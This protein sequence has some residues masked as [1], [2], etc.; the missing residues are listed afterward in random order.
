MIKKPKIAWLH[1][2]ICYW[3]GGTK[4]IY[5]TTSELRKFYDITLFVEDYDNSVKTDFE[6][7][8]IKVKRSNPLSSNKAIYWIIF[9]LVLINEYIYFKRVLKNYDYVISSMF[10]MNILANLTSRG[11]HVQFIFEP[12]AFFYDKDMINGYPLIKKLALKLISRLYS[13]LDMLFT[14]K[15]RQILTVNKNV[16]EWIHK[17]YKKDSLPSYLIIDSAIFRPIKQNYFGNKLQDNKIVLHTTDYT[18]IKR[19]D[20]LIISF[21][22]VVKEVPSAILC[23]TH[24]VDDVDKRR[25]LRSLCKV[26]G[27]ERN[28][29]FLGFVKNEDLPNLYSSVNCGIYPG[30][31]SGASACSYFVLELM[32][33][34]TPVVRTSDSTEEIDDGV[35]GYLFDP[36]NESEMVRKL[37]ILLKNNKLSEKMGVQGRLKIKNI[38]CADNVIKN[39][40]LALKGVKYQN[41]YDRK[42]NC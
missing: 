2:H 41:N 39:F 23:I 8:N 9:P 5:R 40:N 42:S 27:I 11:K 29:K 1:T 12:F 33:C 31:G 21:V 26:L 30:I 20:Y 28:V 38:Y 24:T 37:V 17:I 35:S 32:S 15:S 19:T 13:W 4:F 10:P 7:N 6:K 25:E 16:S 22:E 34:A 36:Q 18:P 14:Q 3:N